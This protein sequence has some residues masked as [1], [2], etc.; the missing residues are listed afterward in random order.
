MA[1]NI[2]FEKTLEDLNTL[3]DKMEQGDLALETSLK[4]FEQGVGLIRQCQTALKTAEQKIQI[5]TEKNNK[6]ELQD[7]D[8]E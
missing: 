4:Y 2:N 7:Y 6:L 5:L 8:V 3:I 1:N